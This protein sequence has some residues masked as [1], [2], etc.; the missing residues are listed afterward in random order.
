MNE[1]QLKQPKKRGRKRRI[2][3]II[4]EDKDIIQPKAKKG[5]KKKGELQ[6][7]TEQQPPDD[8]NSNNN[9]N[10][11]S[12]ENKQIIQDSKIKQR[13]Q[14]QSKKQKTIFQNISQLYIEWGASLISTLLSYQAYVPNSE[15]ECR[16][17]EIK[18]GKFNAGVSD[19]YFNQFILKVREYGHYENNETSDFSLIYNKD[20]WNNEVVYYYNDHIRSS[21][22]VSAAEKKR[23]YERNNKLHKI[24]IHTDQDLY[25][26]RISLKTEQLLEEKE[27]IDNQL[28]DDRMIK[29]IRYKS[30][31]SYIYPQYCF[32][33]DFT[34]AF[35]QTNEDIIYDANNKTYEIEM[36]ILPQSPNISPI[37]L[38]N[39]MLRLL[40]RDPTSLSQL[41]PL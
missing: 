26:L 12:N 35:I 1:E 38:F 2:E 7:N 16:L 4:I 8:N 14:R 10:N 15:L 17:G 28:Y 31:Q 25:D 41:N 37:L 18:N 22:N 5:R 9:N 36:E 40:G 27:I 33:L 21:C 13:K 34:V 29:S 3:N 23:S 24:D 11:N 30:R 39:Q 20:Q 32:K 6:S 19:Q